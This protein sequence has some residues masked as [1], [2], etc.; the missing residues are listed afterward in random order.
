MGLQITISYPEFAKP[1]FWRVKHDIELPQ[2]IWRAH[3]PE[4]HP[5]FPNHHSEFDRGHQFLSRAMNA[6]ISVGN[7]TSVYHYRLW[8]ANNQGFGMKTDP[9]AN[10]V[11][12]KDLDYLN[13]RV[14]CLTCGGSMIE[15]QDLGE[16]VAVKVLDFNSPPDLT[17]LKSHPQYWTYGTYCGGDGTPRRLPE[18][19]LIT[20]E[21]VPVIHPLIAN[22]KKYPI[23]VIPKYKLQLWTQA[24]PPDPYRVYL[25][26]P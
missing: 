8:I 20:G 11:A 5:L 13:P 17:W 10:W 14:E 4:V 16:N 23:L 26:K 6:R 25:T 9:R 2:G 19:T 7:W 21:V 1:V 22:P 15:G 12:G 18:G 3:L 24:L